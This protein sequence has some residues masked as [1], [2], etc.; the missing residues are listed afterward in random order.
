MASSDTPAFIMHQTQQNI[1]QPSQMQLSPGCYSNNILI[2]NGRNVILNSIQGVQTQPI[3]NAQQSQQSIPY[4]MTHPIAIPTTN[5]ITTNS[6]INPLDVAM[7]IAQ[8]YQTAPNQVITHACAQLDTPTQAQIP[9]STT[10]INGVAP[11]QI[12]NANISCSHPINTINNIPYDSSYQSSISPS[13]AVITNSQPTLL[14]TNLSLPNATVN[15]PTTHC[16]P[17]PSTHSQPATPRFQPDANSNSNNVATFTFPNVSLSVPPAVPKTNV[18]LNQSH[19]MLE[20]P[21]DTEKLKRFACKY[22][23]KRF[24]RK[25]N[26]KKHTLIHTGERHFKC[27]HCTKSFSQKHTYVVFIIFCYIYHLVHTYFGLN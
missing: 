22:C 24:N 12:A 27:S 14:L 7:N 26:M 11:T 4:Y 8:T 17:S 20:P 5:R 16:T 3:L 15:L 13:P 10:N 19:S 1:V 23:S 21:F 9:I 2:G 6:Y 18:A 25:S